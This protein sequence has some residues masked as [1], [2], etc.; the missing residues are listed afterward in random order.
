MIV[1]RLL[2]GLGNQMFQ[3]AAGL[4]LAE[5]RRTVLKL[6][7]GWYREDPAYEAHNRYG[8]SCF[9]ITEQF[10]T[11][12]EIE[13]LRGAPL[14]RAER[15]S[16]RC[17]RRLHFYRYV[18]AHARPGHWHRAASAAFSP[19]FFEQPDDTYLDGMW[20]SERFFE[21]AAQRVRLH[22]SFRYPAPPAIAE[23]AERI[24][25]GG[26]SVAVHFRRGDY[27]RNPVFSR[28]IGVLGLDF[29]ERALAALR[30]RVPRV[31]LYIFSD[32]LDA[33]EREFQ[34]A[35]PRVYVR[36]APAL[37]HDKLR[38]ISLCDHA[39]LS[40]STFA[41]WGAWL[42]PNPSKIVIAPNPWHADPNILSGDIVPSAWIRLQRRL[43]A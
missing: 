32:D 15:W 35:G 21:A 38:L 33:V 37:A 20:Q 26:P 29:Y 34:P 5:R 13:R 2:G 28:E 4:A 9:N 23:A 11:R 24:R 18:Q 1:T 12:E 31:T 39:I 8:L 7:V 6:D 27:A 14:T 19:D 42:N 41:W 10:A 16:V 30:E 3:Y 43:P 17:A 40:N 25:T 36:T 22:F